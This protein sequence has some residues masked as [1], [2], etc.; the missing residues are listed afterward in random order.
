MRCFFEG[1]GLGVLEVRD[2]KGSGCDGDEGIGEAG[3]ESHSLGH[4]GKGQVLS[5]ASS[6]WQYGRIFSYRYHRRLA[7]RP[8]G[9]ITGGIVEVV[10]FHGCFFFRMLT[11]TVVESDISLQRTFPRFDLLQVK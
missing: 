3:G 2:D 1:G 11:S 10:G 6:V 9:L 5:L 8:L 4:E 7:S